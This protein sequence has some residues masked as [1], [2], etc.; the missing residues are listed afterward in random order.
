MFLLTALPILLYSGTT[1]KIAGI[2]KDKETGEPLMGVN[3]IIEGTM[4]GAATDMVGEYYVINVP[5]GNYSVKASIIGYKVFT[6][7][8][9]RVVPDLTTKVDFTLE[10]EVIAGETVTI[11]AEK[12]LIQKDVTFSGSMTTAEEIVN[13]PVNSFADVMSLSSGFIVYGKGSVDAAEPEGIHVR[14]G[15][16]NEI[17]YMID[18]FYVK[19]PYSGG[20]AAD[21]PTQGIQDLSVI[22][23]TFNAEYGEAMS[24]I[25]NI[26][27]KEGPP[28]Y[29]GLL[30]FSSDQFGV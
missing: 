25:V 29:H 14:G 17:G 9:V 3:V 2:V 18:G 24:G 15:R 19:D 20:A 13:M 5:P 21:V 10:Q 11:V 1:G 30:R 7:S 16:S 26:V 22:T 27:T 12:P 4:M 8:K 28:A 6:V 23:G